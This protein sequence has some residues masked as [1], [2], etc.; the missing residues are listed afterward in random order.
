MPG[1][2]RTDPRIIKPIKSTKKR[3]LVKVV[4][5]IDLFIVSLVNHVNNTAKQVRQM[6]INVQDITMF[7]PLERSIKSTLSTISPSREI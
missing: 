5:H 3:Q 6:A 2:T 4:Q 1:A 7:E